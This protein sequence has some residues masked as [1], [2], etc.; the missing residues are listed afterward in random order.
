MPPLLLWRESQKAQVHTCRHRL[1]YYTTSLW[2]GTAIN[3][4]WEKALDG[5]SCLCSAWRGTWNLGRAPSRLCTDGIFT[6]FSSQELS[7]RRLPSCENCRAG[8][9]P[10]QPPRLSAAAVGVLGSSPALCS[11]LPNLLEFPAVRS[12]CL[13]PGPSSDRDP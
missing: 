6:S 11:R 3:L 1:G 4:E 13:E 9:L 12:V 2:Q 7:L 10:P 8:P 5:L